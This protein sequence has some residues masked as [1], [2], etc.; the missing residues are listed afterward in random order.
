[1]TPLRPGTIAHSVFI[2]FHDAVSDQQRETLIAEIQNLGE[3][4][5]GKEQG[6]LFWQVGRNRDQR[7]NWHFVEL[8][9]FEDS[10][11]MERFRVHP[12]HATHSEAMRSL[13]DWVV[14]DLDITDV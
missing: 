8:A 12:A 10:A 7:K 14:G 2:R 5:G 6:I 13:A 11:A 4:C 9:V 1:M 3:A